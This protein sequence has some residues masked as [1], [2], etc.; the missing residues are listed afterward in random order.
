[1][2]ELRLAKLMSQ[3]GICSRR[4]AEEYIEKGHVQV[5][6]KIIDKQGVK[7]LETD[8][9]KLLP[10]ACREQKNKVVILLNKP[11]GYVSTQP[12]KNY[13]AAI[14]L[15]TVQNQF[16]PEYKKFDNSYKK[17]LAVA[18]RLDID[19]KG[20]LIFSQDGTIVK[21]IIGP[22]SET[23]KEYMVKVKGFVNPKLL[24]KLAFGLSLDDK[25]LKRAKVDLLAP[26]YMRFVLK[27]G[28]KRQIRRMCELVNLRV[29]SLKRVRIGKVR[30]GNLPVG[31][32]RFLK[33]SE[34]I[35]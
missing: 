15:I 18:G 2:K 16:D 31:K 14:E 35:L 6:G 29:I 1:M 21:Q 20:L 19:S 26:D 9:I 10:E 7:V 17:K 11:L 12:E 8:E 32:W 25:P 5:N 4:E 34:F 22:D 23:E 13:K 27:E 30:L 28:K 24:E 33:N 3:K